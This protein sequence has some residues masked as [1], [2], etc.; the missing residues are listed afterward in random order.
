MKGKLILLWLFIVSV[1]AV[2]NANN[3]VIAITT[4][5]TYKVPFCINVLANDVINM[6]TVLSVAINGSGFAFSNAGPVFIEPVRI[7]II[8]IHNKQ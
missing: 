2:I 1:D 5:T 4:N 8:C 3:D 7:K 6:D